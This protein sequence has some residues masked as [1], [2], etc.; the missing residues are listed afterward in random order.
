MIGP[1]VLRNIP[2][3]YDHLGML[4]YHLMAIGFISIA[5]KK[6]TSMTSKSSVDTGFFI[7]AS[8]V[9]QGIVGFGLTFLLI[10]T[11][12]KDIFPPFGFLLPLGF[13]QGPGQAF[14]MGTRWD[15]LTA[16]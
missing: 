15:L 12:F 10:A 7:A 2:F 9:I 8:Y 5:L 16:A 13:A 6:R 3:S 4:V 14:S 1:S 11:F